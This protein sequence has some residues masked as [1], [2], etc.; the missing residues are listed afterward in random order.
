M[1]SLHLL[2]FV[3]IIYS[4]SNDNEYDTRKTLI[5]WVITNSQGQ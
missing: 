3:V 5:A 4:K 1:P 2:S